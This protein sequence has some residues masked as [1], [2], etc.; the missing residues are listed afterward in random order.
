MVGVTDIVP[1]ALG[2]PRIP[3]TSNSLTLNSP[4]PLSHPGTWMGHEMAGAESVSWPNPVQE[5]LD[6]S[7]QEG[8]SFKH[9]VVASC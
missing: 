3:G 1:S 5:E 8:R 4:I 6:F 9:D 7:N 2:Q